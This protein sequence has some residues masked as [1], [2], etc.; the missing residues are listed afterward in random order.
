MMRS[1]IGIWA[2]VL[3]G[4]AA[5]CAA[6]P[7]RVVTL[8]TVLT[9]IARRVGGPD[10]SVTGLVKPGVD[11]H[12]F[13]PAPADVEPLTNAD[14]VLA[15][16]LGMEPYL[17]R[18]VANSGTH[19]QILQ[20]GDC[21]GGN[22]PTLATYGR[23]EPDPHW[24]NSVIATEA[25][26]ARVARALCSLRPAEAARFEARAATYLGQL[27]A[28]DRWTRAQLAPIPPSRRILVTTHDAFGWFARDYGFRVLYLSGLSPDTE[29][30]A[31]TLA[32][33][34]DSI[35]AS[36]VPSLFVENSANPRLVEAVVQETGVSLGG[37]LWPDGLI[38]EPDGASYLELFRH[39]VRTIAA[40]LEH[41]IHHE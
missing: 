12:T 41:P 32:R 25:V 4:S 14:L 7:V 24:W 39:N 40:G 15:C 6:A 19:A 27:K 13:Q 28:L 21:F 2:A 11:P 26:V 29:P 30:D 10:V 34:I 5:V 31:R 33:T 35:R 8:G 36:G 1:A 23:R 22:V 20:A 18:L 3:L 16:G 37:T 9:E 17:D 38:A